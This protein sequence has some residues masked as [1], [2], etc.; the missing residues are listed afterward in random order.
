MINRGFPKP[1]IEGSR[2]GKLWSDFLLS[3]EFMMKALICDVCKNAIQQPVHER[4]Y[5]H[6]AHRDICE[7]CKDQLELVLKPVIRTKEPFNYEWF[8]RLEQDLIERAVQR[9]KF[10]AAQ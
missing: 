5:F 4:N 3:K 10:E 9:G 8:Y 6:I 1:R 7:P 2:F